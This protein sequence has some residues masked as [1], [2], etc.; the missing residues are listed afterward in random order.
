V[1]RHG[2][3]VVGSGRNTVSK[4]GRFST[5]FR[6]LIIVTAIR[7][8]CRHVLFWLMYHSTTLEGS[9]QPKKTLL[10]V[11]TGTGFRIFCFL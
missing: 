9:C 5:R 1:S 8:G 7:D 4:R 2:E 3:A 6:C 10:I 11:E